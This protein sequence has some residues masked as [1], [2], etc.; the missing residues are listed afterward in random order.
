MELVLHTKV[1]A[2][3]RLARTGVS[4]FEFLPS[5]I[6]L[7]CLSCPL[8]RLCNESICILEHGRLDRGPLLTESGKTLLDHTRKIFSYA[9]T[10][11]YRE[12]LKEATPLVIHDPLEDIVPNL[13]QGPILPWVSTRPVTSPCVPR[14]DPK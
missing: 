14:M 9:A 12:I 8:S 1:F 2:I 7:L 11:G 13:P 5:V 4:A 10:A 6:K 3:Y